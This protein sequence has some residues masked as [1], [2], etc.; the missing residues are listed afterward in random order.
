MMKNPSR[1][2][3]GLGKDIVKA[4]SVSIRGSNSG[5]A[6]KPPQQPNELEAQEDDLHRPR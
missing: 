4:Q 6:S 5:T 3:R 1:I 2:F